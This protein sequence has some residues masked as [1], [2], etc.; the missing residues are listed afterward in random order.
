M[1][2]AGA[3]A[4]AAL[5]GAS[6]FGWWGCA[7]RRGLS[8]EGARVLHDGSERHDGAGAHVDR[9]LRQRGGAGLR[10]SLIHISEPTR[11]S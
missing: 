9:H 3:V 8:W 11:R 2:V 7:G 6:R 10:L 5:T 4:F 1:T